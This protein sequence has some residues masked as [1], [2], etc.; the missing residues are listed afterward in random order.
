MKINEATFDLVRKW[1][2]FKARAYYCPA[3][4]LTIGFGTTNRAQLPGVRITE[5]LEI[6]RAQGEEWLRAGLEKFGASIRPLITAPI[7]ENE[8]GAFV[9]LAYNIGI[10][11]FRGSSA[12]RHFNAGDKAKAAAAI[13]LWNKATVNGKRQVLRGLVNRREEEVAL[14]LKPVVSQP[15]A[16]KPVVNHKDPIRERQSPLAALFAAFAALFKRNDK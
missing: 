13:K 5:G 9:S 12:L 1:E 4:V 15:L 14:F 7:N 2:G 3:G 6:T 10:G 16:S 11:G 8:F